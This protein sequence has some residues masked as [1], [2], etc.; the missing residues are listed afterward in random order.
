MLF[1][2]RQNY[3][4]LYVTKASFVWNGL[5]LFCGAIHGEKSIYQRGFGTDDIPVE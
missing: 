3:I 4:F 5:T 1:E 2:G